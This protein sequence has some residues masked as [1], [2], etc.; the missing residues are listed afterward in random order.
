[1]EAK[2]RKKTNKELS[3]FFD[4]QCVICAKEIDIYKRKDKNKKI[5]FVDI[6]A[7]KFDASAEG[8]DPKKVK[9][10][11]H[12]KDSKGVLHT[13]VDG[14]IMIWDVLNIFRPLSCLAKSSFVRPVFDLGYFAFTKARPFLPRKD[15]DDGSC[16]I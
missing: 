14:F 4:G 9:T 10:V 13:G 16:E 12:V 11:F 8:L 7:A 1:M 15:C 5:N 6:S 3:V 2:K